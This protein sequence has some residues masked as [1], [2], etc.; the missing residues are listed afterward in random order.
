MNCRQQSTV[1]YHNCIR[2]WLRKGRGI[3]T[4]KNLV[5]LT[6]M[7]SGLVGPSMRKGNP[8]KDYTGLLV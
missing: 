4:V 1:F 2:N 3:I 6:T 8:S 5:E 7:D